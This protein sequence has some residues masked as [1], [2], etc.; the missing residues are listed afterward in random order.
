M[1]ERALLLPR[2]CA[3]RGLLLS[4]TSVV[5]LRTWGYKLPWF[6]AQSINLDPAFFLKCEQTVDIFSL[7]PETVF[8]IIILKT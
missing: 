8:V 4:S 7:F 1:L 6:R 2:V 3:D 5:P